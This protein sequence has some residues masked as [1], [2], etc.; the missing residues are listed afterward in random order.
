MKK[1]SKIFS[2]GLVVLFCFGF[3]KATLSST[4]PM[5]FFIGEESLNPEN[6][7]ILKGISIFF[8]LV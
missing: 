8:K 6:P 5:V 3:S 2:I 4:G 7:F 1:I